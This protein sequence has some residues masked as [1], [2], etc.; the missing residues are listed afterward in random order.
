M[1]PK[2]GAR[3]QQNAEA[4]EKKR[5]EIAAKHAQD[6]ADDIAHY[7]S[8]R[9]QHTPK[10]SS[11]ALLPVTTV[12]DDATTSTRDV[13]ALRAGQR[14][15]PRGTND[16]NN[17]CYRN[18][19]LLT[20]LCTDPFMAYIK[21]RWLELRRDA[22]T[23]DLAEEISKPVDEHN[24]PF[25]ILSTLW[26]VYWDPK[27]PDKDLKKAMDEAWK[28][29][30]NLPNVSQQWATG[31]QYRAQQDAHEFLNWLLSAEEESLL[32]LRGIYDDYRSIFSMLT[33]QRQLCALCAKDGAIRH[34]SKQMTAHAIWEVGLPPNH[35]H[36]FRLDDLMQRYF[37]YV[38]DGW[39]CDE[40][41][42]KLAMQPEKREE[43]RNQ[44]KGPGW[45]YV[46]RLPEV[47]F[48]QLMRAEWTVDGILEKNHLSVEIPATINLER[49]LDPDPL[50][51]DRE[52]LN[53]EYELTGVITHQGRANS[54]HYK[55][56]VCVDKEWYCINK[57][58]CEP[59]SF[60]DAIDKEHPKGF[61]PYMLVW[62]RKSTSSTVDRA[63]EKQTASAPANAP[64]KALATSTIT[65]DG[66]N[67]PQ[68]NSTRRASARSHTSGQPGLSNSPRGSI[69]EDLS[70]YLRFQVALGGSRPY[71]VHHEIPTQPDLVYAA[72]SG[73][74]PNVDIAMTLVQEDKS[75]K[76]AFELD[77]LAAAATEDR[78]LNENHLSTPELGTRQSC[79]CTEVHEGTC[80]DIVKPSE[81]GGKRKALPEGHR[82]RDAAPTA[83]FKR[84]K[85]LPNI[86]A[87]PGDDPH[88]Y[89]SPAKRWRSQR[90]LD[91]AIYE[92]ETKWKHL[93]APRAMPVAPKRE[94]WQ[95]LSRAP[96]RRYTSSNPSTP[97]VRN[98]GRPGASSVGNQRTGSRMLPFYPAPYVGR[99]NKRRFSSGVPGTPKMNRGN[100]GVSSV[101][102]RRSGPILPF[103]VAQYGKGVGK[104]KRG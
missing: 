79:R 46:R 65:Q 82:D 34:T 29:M 31:R 55:T 84:T 92:F 28:E 59:S 78:K 54:G 25:E 16:D 35:N 5:A 21:N 1:P 40:C 67:V 89:P 68:R 22:I 26:D 13:A 58:E 32:D 63:T 72:S 12:E 88:G 33:T 56:H 75:T 2:K 39:L 38:A 91:R 93:Q 74:G 3:S 14:L 30:R 99:K 4:K 90:A 41:D 53:P 9:N 61:T 77:L 7:D 76:T 81:A 52:R 94:A 104:G 71:L 57:K 87:R 97:P 19:V 103:D 85:R 11:G 18:A 47:L 20:L 8:V 95:P 17:A 6:Y 49:Y 15:G 37:K 23:Q 42:Q 83:P 70:T 45:R 36:Q 101:G 50:M 98:H 73:N 48:M 102:G 62:Q 66:Q 100:K 64:D 43:L 60:E 44:F 86:F 80:K 51:L 10:H 69:T 27:K 96:E 24:H